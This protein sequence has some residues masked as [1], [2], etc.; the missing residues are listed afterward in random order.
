MSSS[1]RPPD[2]T[3]VIPAYNAQA[4][5]DETLRTVRAQTHANLE[6]LV[7]DDGSTDSTPQIV[8]RHAQQ[9]AR[10][11]LIR[12][13]NGG[14][15]A[16]RNAGANAARGEFLAPVDADDLW[17]PRKIELQLDV[18]RNGPSDLGLVYTWFALIDEHSNIIHTK[19]NPAF[20]GQ[21]LPVLAHYNFI[22]NG[23]S[24]LIRLSA[25]RASPGYDPSLKAR[26]GQGC[27]D[28][29]L[30][31]QL[32]DKHRI[33]VVKAHLVGY[34]L[35]DDNMSSD[36]LQMLRSRDLATKDIVAAHPELAAAL[37][38]G[39][40]RL[41]RYLLHRAIRQGR[42]QNIN[43]LL[44]SMARHDRMFVLRTLA[45]M[46]FYGLDTLRHRIA[47]RWSHGQTQPF[48][49]IREP[50]KVLTAT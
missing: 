35:L 27:E 25:F 22:G 6:I 39:R 41:S 28:W 40:N 45:T 10:I 20:S 47:G 9:D 4:T 11:R 5:I 26:G 31:C 16:A 36:A 7:V 1:D 43:R 34:R 29:K 21:V 19:H 8:E 32:A 17:H 50:R 49:R 24:P 15:A 44:R 30:Y 42:L 2:V 23:S 33:G 37:H 13:N 12:Q 3:V 14:V 38:Q 18:F 48:G 46:P